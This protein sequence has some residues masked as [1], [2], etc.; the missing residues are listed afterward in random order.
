MYFTVM[1]PPAGYEK[2]CESEIIVPKKYYLSNSLRW[3][4]DF[5][6]CLILLRLAENWVKIIFG[7]DQRYLS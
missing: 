3:N 4:D 5:G 1:S 6:T 2:I 7:L